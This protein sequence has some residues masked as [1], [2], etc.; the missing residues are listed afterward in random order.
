MKTNKE[1]RDQVFEI[2]EN[3]LNENDPP[4]T[5]VTFDRLRKEGFDDLQAKQLIGQCLIVEIFDVIKYGKEY[6]NER[7]IQ[8][9]KA[10]PKEPFD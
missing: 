10:L 2:I 7:Y 5:K 6:N 3:Q 1:M 9:L 8:N 4:E